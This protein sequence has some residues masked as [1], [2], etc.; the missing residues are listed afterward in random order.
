M[1]RADPTNPAA[2][3][4]VVVNDEEQYSLWPAHRALPPG[5]FR[6]GEPTSRPDGL[7]RI[8]ELW[9]DL[10]PASLRRAL[11]GSGEDRR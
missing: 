8:A 1:S 11:A 9:T 7:A 2:T 5:W 10:R 6:V 4:V 3:H